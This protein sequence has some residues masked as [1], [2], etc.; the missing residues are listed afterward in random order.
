[1]LLAI[2]GTAGVVIA[3]V[4]VGLW[5][6]RRVSILPRP[7]ELAAAAE[8]PKKKEQHAPGAAA[9]TAIRA[10]EHQ[11]ARLARRRH[12]GAR[13]ARDPDDLVRFGD[14]TLTVLRF[15]CAAC[16]ARDRVYLTRT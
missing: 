5:V 16:G 6:D 4:A 13:M 7:E 12:C 9:E 2:L 14:A 10:D 11:I 1:M 3:F 15:H 8:A